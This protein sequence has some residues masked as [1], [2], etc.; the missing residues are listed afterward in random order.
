MS[1]KVRVYLTKYALTTCIQVIDAEKE[2]SSYYTPGQF[3]LS[4]GG[5]LWNGWQTYRVGKD[6]FFSK[7]A[8]IEA[9]EEKRTKKLVSLKKQIAKL[10]AMTFEVEK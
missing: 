8:A 4:A 9:A 1:E 6:F 7:E 3:E 10:E 5:D 2:A